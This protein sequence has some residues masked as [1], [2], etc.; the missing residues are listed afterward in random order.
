[1]TIK[2]LSLVIPAYKQEKTIVKD[3]ESINKVLKKLPYNYE[4][5]IVVDGCRKTYKKTLEI[6]NPKV[7]VFGYEKNQGKGHAVKYGVNKAK[8][9][10]IG[11]IDGGRDI[12]SISII[13]LLPTIL[14]AVQPRMGGGGS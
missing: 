9:N 4:I 11:F 3:V 1:M 14:S 5:I 10:I 8:G 6:K 2:N 13:P 7:K 12:D